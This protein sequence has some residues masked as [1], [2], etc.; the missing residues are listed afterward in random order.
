MNSRRT[1]SNACAI[2]IISISC[3][4]NLAT[5][6]QEEKEQQKDSSKAR[7]TKA[8]NTILKAMREVDDEGNDISK[9][10][11]S[12]FC[13]K[14][15]EQFK[16]IDDKDV[17]KDISEKFKS[18]K[19]KFEKFYN[20]FR[21]FEDKEIEELLELVGES[22][23]DYGKSCEELLKAAKDAGYEIVDP[24]YSD[25]SGDPKKNE[26]KAKIQAL[27]MAIQMYRLD[28]NDYPDKLTHLV[29][30]PANEKHRM[31]WGGPYID[32][33]LNALSDAWGTSIAFSVDMETGKIMLK[34]AGPDA[35]FETEDD[36]TNK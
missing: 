25:G 14:I 13:K 5:G 11:V 19:A 36:I 16:S 12:R 17:P 18:A 30:K 3:F 2:L 28:V 27:K 21:E 34:S 4:S 23:R 29:E 26:T 35:K 7:I 32:K 8:I 20:S 22:A 6:F 33:K 1:V 10:F 15:D 24:R 9:E 31:K